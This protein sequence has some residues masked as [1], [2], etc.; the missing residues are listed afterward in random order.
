MWARDAHELM[1]EQRGTALTGF[2][3]NMRHK[4]TAALL[5]ART[6]FDLSRQKH[7]SSENGSCLSKD[8]SNRCW[9][10]PPRDDLHSLM[11][12]STTKLSRSRAYTVPFIDRK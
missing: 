6:A 5:S 7:R 9:T 11:F 8:E 10:M 4:L 3:A 2:F 1:Q 12:Q